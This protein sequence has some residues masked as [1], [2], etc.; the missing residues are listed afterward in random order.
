MCPF[1]LWYKWSCTSTV[2]FCTLIAPAS[3]PA[4]AAKGAQELQQKALRQSAAAF[5]STVDFPLL[6]EG[7]SIAACAAAGLAGGAESLSVQTCADVELNPCCL[8]RQHAGWQA[9]QVLYRFMTCGSTSSAA[10][11]MVLFFACGSHPAVHAPPLTPFSF[12]SNSSLNDVAQVLQQ[13]YLPLAEAEDGSC[14]DASNA[15][16]LLLSRRSIC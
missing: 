11:V 7:T 8:Q 1:S 9:A 14:K 6:A 5:P 10:A 15:A 12:G 2:G 13:A 16:V 3:L 4:E